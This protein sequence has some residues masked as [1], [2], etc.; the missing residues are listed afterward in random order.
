MFDD[1]RIF[2]GRF[3]WLAG[4]LLLAGLAT[5]CA[6]DTDKS[7]GELKDDSF[8]AASAG[9]A[10]SV[11]NIQPGSAE[12]EGV[13]ELVNT[14]SLETLDK[15]S[16]IGLDVRAAHN[17]VDERQDGDISSLQEL[18]NIPWVSRR[19]F[20]KLYDYAEANGYFSEAG[21]ETETV[22][23]IE[24]G[25]E[26]AKDIFTLVTGAS[27]E[28]LS[29]SDGVGLDDRVAESIVT[30][31]KRYGLENIKE[32][33]KVSD[34]DGQT[35]DRLEAYVNANDVGAEN[36]DVVS[37]SFDAKHAV[38]EDLAV[39][40]DGSVIVSGITDA[41]KLG[42]EDT[43]GS[44]EKG[45]VASYTPEG[46]QRWIRHFSTWYR[47]EGHKQNMVAD[48]SGI[49]VTYSP[50]NNRVLETTLVKLTHSNEIAWEYSGK[51]GPAEVKRLGEDNLYIE[52]PNYSRSASKYINTEIW[53]VRK[54]SG[55]YVAEYHKRNTDTDGRSAHYYKHFK[56]IPFKQG[57]IAA[58]R[59]Y[60]TSEI[61][62]G[63]PFRKMD[64]TLGWQRHGPD[65][66]HQWSSNLK[67]T[68]DF[69]NSTRPVIE[70]MG[71]DTD[72]DI[73]TVAG[74][75]YMSGGVKKHMLYKHTAD[76]K[77]QWRESFTIEDDFGDNFIE[78]MVVAEDTAYVLADLD[79]DDMDMS[80]LVVVSFEDSGDSPQ[81][82]SRT[83]L[84]L[85]L[86]EFE[87]EKD[88]YMKMSPET[89]RAY[90]ADKDDGSYRITGFRFTQP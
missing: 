38:V 17:I 81:K 40:P 36:R 80:N 8:L 64:S 60:D 15:G 11:F 21:G 85:E 52:K 55:D 57:I 76:G 24:P 45:F 87:P 12:A 5:G 56:F 32:L 26:T 84:D 23:G 65:G 37:I 83:K 27:L 82:T 19:A 33:A 71:A 53:G 43:Y 9:K 34:V 4:T 35:F 50:E 62:D 41:E 7:G 28:L 70:G 49:Y 67:I 68:K 3:V 30:A 29:R 42:G 66:N 2:D 18:D 79:L 44:Q 86:A 59:R 51:W 77:L 72:G 73:W 20:R 39:T 61:E 46:K 90:F 1:T 31:R 58:Y 10:D 22:Y 78:D 75:N 6:G 63:K 89:K 88:D 25:S 48:A 14:A 47:H 16:E 69:A 54:D 74:F 13:L